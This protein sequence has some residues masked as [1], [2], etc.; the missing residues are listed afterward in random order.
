M[1]AYKRK[2]IGFTICILRYVNDLPY[3]IYLFAKNHTL[4]IC[5]VIAIKS[6]SNRIFTTISPSGYL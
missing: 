2:F 4:P 6:H 5:L 3:Q 1:Y